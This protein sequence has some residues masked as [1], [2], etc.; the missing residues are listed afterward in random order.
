MRSKCRR[1]FWDLFNRLPEYV[2]REA[3]N[4]YRDFRTDPGMP[5]LNF[6]AVTPKRIVWSVR[7]TGQYRALGARKAESPDLIVWFWIGTHNDY[8]KLINQLRRSESKL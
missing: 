3:R 1:S 6:E 7:I 2:Q 5:G 8:D 4:A